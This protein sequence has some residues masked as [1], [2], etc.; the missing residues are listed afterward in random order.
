[1]S[2]NKRSLCIMS[3]THTNRH[4]NSTI[5]LHVCNKPVRMRSIQHATCSASSTLKHMGGLNFKMFSQG[6]SVLTQILSSSFNL[7][8]AGSKVTISQKWRSSKEW[9][10]LYLF[11]NKAAVSVAGVLFSLSV[12]SSTPTNSP[13]PLG[14]IQQSSSSSSAILQGRQNKT[15]QRHDVTINANTT[16][17]YLEIYGLLRCSFTLHMPDGSGIVHSKKIMKLVMSTPGLSPA[18]SNLRL[19]YNSVTSPNIC[20]A[21]RV[22][23]NV[24]PSIE[25][26]LLKPKCVDTAAV[27]R[28]IV[29]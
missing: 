1:M 22:P 12:T 7:V 3:L 19:N 24:L 14:E 26:L 15:A 18:D 5:K 29:E 25:W 10:V 23:V 20:S 13:T 8:Y 6:P 21:E 28:N 9:V 11:T 27:F 4:T 17:I 2:E 16:L